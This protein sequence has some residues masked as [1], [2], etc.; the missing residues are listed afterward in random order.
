MKDDDK[1][2]QSVGN[3]KKIKQLDIEVPALLDALYSLDAKD[4]ELDLEETRY[5][6][7]AYVQVSGGEVSIDF[8]EMPGIKRD[9]KH[10]VRGIR[11][12]LAHSSAQRL[13]EVLPS[14]LEEI[15]GRSQMEEHKP[16]TDK[17]AGGA[18]KTKTP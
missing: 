9:G 13:A 14:V 2:V 6:N 11:V 15:P 7:L 8:L 5:S 18:K 12:Y 4:V 16:T 10:L 17:K 3:I 1:K